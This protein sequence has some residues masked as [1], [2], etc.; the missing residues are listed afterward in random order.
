[1]GGP[2][3]SFSFAFVPSLTAYPLPLKKISSMGLDRNG[4]LD[5]N[6]FI[7]ELNILCLYNTL[8]SFSS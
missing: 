6:E 4:R 8:I 1:M 2:C 7:F 3:G 5:Y